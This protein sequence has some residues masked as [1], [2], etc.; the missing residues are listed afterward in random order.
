MPG[1]KTREIWNLGEEVLST[2]L[3]RI[4]L[5]IGKEALDA[6][7][8]RS[9]RADFYD[10]SANVFDDFS[11]S[12]ASL[13]TPIFG[14]LKPPSLVG[15]TSGFN[16]TIGAGEGEMLGSG[17][18]PDDESAY[19]LHRWEEQELV[20]PVE[21]QPDSSNPR[22]CL[23]VSTAA[24]ESAERQNRNLLLDKNTRQTVPVDV[25]KLSQPMA[26]LS[27]VAGTA[28]STPSAPDVPSGT[29]PLFEIWIPASSSNSAAFGIVRRAWRR[30]EFPGTSQHG[31]VKNC[32]P[33]LTSTS[34]VGLPAGIHRLVIDGEL[35]TWAHTQTLPLAADQFSPPTGG[36]AGYDMPTYLYLCGGRN[37]PY[38][39]Q[40][41]HPGP[42]APGSFAPVI[43]IE[44]ATPPDPMGYPTADIGFVSPAV[45]F[46]RAACC[47]IG[48]RFKASADDSN[49]PSVYDGD[50]ILPTRMV[51][52]VQPSITEDSSAT[53]KSIAMATVPATSTAMRVRGYLVGTAS[54]L[55]RV[56]RSAHDVDQIMI[57]SS[58]DRDRTV[59]TAASG[60][61]YHYALVTGDTLSLRAIGFNMNIPRLGR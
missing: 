49:V 43:L 38:R 61:L 33:Q 40:G 18:I 55:V 37:G 21:G 8:L 29:M 11:S 27:V 34:F 15:S 16:M 32:V 20:W 28:A 57:M 48:V 46:A 35:L 6:D 14:L 58:A 31:I 52:F 4:G 56:S 26:T 51:N 36:H 59:D 25:Y 42:G 10:P 47:Y 12:K 53:Y 45:T 13:A 41:V 23:I 17:T 30:V 7:E 22:I 5:L 3:T 60:T 39:S 2:D 19:Q 24:D 50:W 44:S 9:V 54:P 1:Q